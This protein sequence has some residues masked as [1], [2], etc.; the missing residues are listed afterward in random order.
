MRA[1]LRWRVVCPHDIEVA[2]GRT[3]EIVLY[4][5]RYDIRQIA[6]HVELLRGYCHVGAEVSYDDFGG[7]ESQG[8]WSSIDL[9]VSQTE[10]IAQSENGRGRD[11]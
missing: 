9:N 6:F 4:S 3:D 2:E 1:R 8:F 5:G 10:R 11:V 7:G